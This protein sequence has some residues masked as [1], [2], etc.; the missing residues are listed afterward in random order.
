[1]LLFGAY[2]LVELTRCTYINR[3]KGDKEGGHRG[4]RTHGRKNWLTY[5]WKTILQKLELV[6]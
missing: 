2:T 3:I 5:D 4:C 6:F 1:M